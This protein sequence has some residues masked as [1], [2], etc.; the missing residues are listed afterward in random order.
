MPNEAEK[1]ERLEEQHNAEFKETATKRA[2]T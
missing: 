1:P 2:R